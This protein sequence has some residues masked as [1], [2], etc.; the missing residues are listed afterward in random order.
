V[1]EY[2]KNMQISLMWTPVLFSIAES[3][4]NVTF[5]M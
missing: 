5:Y 2:I 4:W 1:E 3:Y